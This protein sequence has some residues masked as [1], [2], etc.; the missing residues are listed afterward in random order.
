[1]SQAQESQKMLISALEKQA[2][3]WSSQ[4][5]NLSD[6]VGFWS[7]KVN[8]RLCR[9]AVA[10]IEQINLD[11]LETAEAFYQQ[12]LEQ[13]FRYTEWGWG[14]SWPDDVH[15]AGIQL[16]KRTVVKQIPQAVRESLSPSFI[17]KIP[18]LKGYLAMLQ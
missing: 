14:S 7:A 13:I 4:K 5:S 3:D 12:A 18:M 11:R 8:A 2:I 17:Q 16:V 10:L 6:S 9:E 15:N 1:M